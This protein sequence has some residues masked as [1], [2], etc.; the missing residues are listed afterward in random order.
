MFPFYHHDTKRLARLEA[1]YGPLEDPAPWD[2]RNIGFYRAGWCLAVLVGLGSLIFNW[3]TPG[4][5]LAAIIAVS[6]L[7]MRGIQHAR[8][9]RI[10][11]ACGW[12]M[13]PKCLYE[14]HRDF[15]SPDDIRTCPECGHKSTYRV[16]ISQWRTS[17]P[18]HAGPDIP[19]LQ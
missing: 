6:T 2:A 19:P 14:V 11:N 4:L 8:V 9:H 12:S 18:P 16:A 1:A 10:G 15:V 7:V 17:F 5:T 13:C 3:L